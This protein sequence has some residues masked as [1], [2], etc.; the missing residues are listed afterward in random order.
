MKAS[1]QSRIH[2]I[3]S[4]FRGFSNADDP[5][6]GKPAVKAA[7]CGRQALVPLPHIIAASLGLLAPQA[8]ALD[9]FRY[10]SLGG[11]QS[12]PTQPY[13]YR[14][15]KM[16]D[17]GSVVGNAEN[18][19]ATWKAGIITK[20]GI[21]PV[22]TSAQA[23]AIN[24][25]D[26]IAIQR[27][28]KN[29]ADQNSAAVKHLGVWYYTS[30]PSGI[31]YTVPYGIN[32]ARLMVGSA[33]SS[34]GVPGYAFFVPAGGDVPTL[35]PNAPGTTRSVALGVNNNKVA[36]GV[37]FSAI[38]NPV[39]MTWIADG[40]GNGQVLGVVGGN[41]SV[42][43]VN[44][45]NVAVGHFGADGVYWD[46][47]GRHV[48]APGIANALTDSGVIVG[49]TAATYSYSASIAWFK[50]PADTTTYSL[51]ALQDSGHTLYT[52]SDI[53][54]SLQIVGV[55][56]TG[57][58]ILTPVVERSVSG[59][60]NDPGK[61]LWE[62][63]PTAV[64]PVRIVPSTVSVTV[65]GPSGTATV[66]EMAVGDPA[67]TL[68][69]TLD[70]AT[71]S[72]LK[73]TGNLWG[74]GKTTVAAKGNVVVDGQI[75]SPADVSGSFSGAGS[76]TGDVVVRSTGLV[77]PGRTAGTL[78]AGGAFN[79]ENGSRLRIDI[80]GQG[81]ST[82]ADKLAVTGSVS[83]SSPTLSFSG[84]HVPVAGETFMILQNN[85]ATPVAGTFKDLPE[86]TKIAN[87]MGSGLEARISYTGGTGNDVTLTTIQ[88][89]STNANLAS[90]S[91]N[92]G[93]LSP[94]FTEPTGSY[95]AEVDY[96]AA[97]T[98]VTSA[99]VE[100]QATVSING[101]AASA[102]GQVET[103][104]LSVGANHVDVLVT[105]PDP[106]NTRH[107]LID[108]Q[109]LS[110]IETLRKEAFGSA[111]GEGETADLADFDGDGQPN[112]LELA[113]GAD[114]KS[115]MME[116]LVYSAGTGAGG[117]IEKT[118]QP[119][120]VQGEEG[121]RVLF[122]RLSAWHE[123]GLSYSPLACSDAASWEPIPAEPEVLADNGTYQIVA[124]PLPSFEEGTGFFRLAVEA[125]E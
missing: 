53:N 89:L 54:S 70:L 67:D 99:S 59:A 22:A 76:V 77:S 115:G 37:S 79:M 117:V 14:S 124:V 9:Y 50:S 42:Q 57:G 113:I 3:G 74:S 92:P 62:L 75:Q 107:Y 48:L 64:H 23:Y 12:V 96:Q 24:A 81:V 32:D 46:N 112:L 41:S 60:W 90:L 122:V 56:D 20:Y 98:T 125:E 100:A 6:V 49:S 83:L 72:I 29:F 91:L 51:T 45:N 66:S 52:A 101:K 80:N 121:R 86:G 71:G 47:S 120:I 21:P 85:S 44:G 84:S 19:P 123:A 108:V 106:A 109:R 94:A 1:P 31:G 58:Y 28:N 82:V 118:G 78:S 13:S 27:N 4:L 39:A 63:Q 87:F 93:L 97:A 105:A 119:V 7:L 65:A 2:T 5:I 25:V 69:A 111:S 40:S 38:N 11:L 18:E 102:G 17:S 10:A 61:W 88:P 73:V 116:T 104:P 15:Y 35:L 33:S 110:V 114:T 34:A 95:T 16:N 103:V 55:S 30:Y 8:G 36:W 26:S 43:D 68:T